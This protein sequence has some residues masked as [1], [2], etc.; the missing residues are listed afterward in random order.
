M[1]KRHIARVDGAST[2]VGNHPHG[3]LVELTPHHVQVTIT[4]GVDGKKRHASALVD[5]D[6]LEAAIAAARAAIDEEVSA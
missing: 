3:V 1:K 5:I 2:G 6:E 4:G